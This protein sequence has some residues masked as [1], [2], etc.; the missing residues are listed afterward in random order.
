[1]FLHRLRAYSSPGIVVGSKFFSSYDETL[2]VASVNQPFLHGFTIH[3]AFW[4]NA[5]KVLRRG[6][7]LTYFLIAELCLTSTRAFFYGLSDIDVCG[8]LGFPSGELGPAVI[9]RPQA[10]PRSSTAPEAAVALAVH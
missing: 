9:S 8:L 4:L 10:M 6:E 3:G 5:G 1:M 7:V 2:S